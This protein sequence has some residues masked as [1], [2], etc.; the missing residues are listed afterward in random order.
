YRT[1]ESAGVRLPDR[2]RGTAE[3]L[4]D[5]FRVAATL[6]V[7]LALPGDVVEIQGV[8]V[9]LIG[10]RGAMANDDHASPGA[11]EL[12]EIAD[13]WGV[14]PQADPTTSPTTRRARLLSAIPMPLP[15]VGV[16]LRSPRARIRS[17]DPRARPAREA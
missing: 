1:A 13:R 17:S 3:H 16:S 7:Q 15:L 4:A 8:G 9:S 12:Q 2:N 10:M 14:C 6:V 11:K 5:R